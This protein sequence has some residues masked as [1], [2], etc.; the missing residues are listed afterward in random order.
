MRNLALRSRAPQRTDRERRKRLWLDPLRADLDTA[1][2]LQMARQHHVSLRFAAQVAG[3]IVNLNSFIDAGYVYASQAGLA[4]YI[5]NENG[6]P[7]CDRQ[8]RRAIDFLV[9][10]KHLRVERSRGT[11]NRMFSLYRAAQPMA[12]PPNEDIMSC[13]Q[14]HDV[15]GVRTSCPPNP[16]I[17]PISETY[18]PQSPPS[19]ESGN[20]VRLGERTAS[21]THD[22]QPSDCDHRERNKRRL[23]EGQEVIHHRLAYRLGFGDVAAGYE[24]LLGLP[25]NRRDEL[26]AM[27]RIGKLNDTEISRALNALQRASR[28]QYQS[29]SLLLTMREQ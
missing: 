28:E 23:I 7:A 25:D 1:E 24:I 2:A 6:Q 3:L 5:K 8:V 15:R 17:K 19:G 9:A 20:V 26:T 21:G 29:E 4:D 13:D 16:I 10:R 22:R 18:T 27:E 12:A 14:G 11:R